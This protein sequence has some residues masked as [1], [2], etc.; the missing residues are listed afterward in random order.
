MA[1]TV[2]EVK[3][4]ILD[5]EAFREFLGSLNL[6][7]EEHQTIMHHPSQ[8]NAECR[9]CDRMSDQLD[10]AIARFCQEAGGS[11]LTFKFDIPK[12]QDQ[13]GQE[14][15]PIIMN[16]EQEQPVEPQTPPIIEQGPNNT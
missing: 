6:I 14:D 16:N 11:D 8:H 10:K 12:V 7:I 13:E 1:Q 3:L 2:A 9:R 4:S 5:I 15:P